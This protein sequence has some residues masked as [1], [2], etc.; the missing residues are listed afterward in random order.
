M[1]LRLLT[2]PEEFA[3][4]RG[5]WDT[6]RRSAR[7]RSVFATHDWFDAA[8]A[9]QGD[10]TAPYILCCERDGALAGVLPLALRRA[11]GRGIG[12][13]VLE[14]LAVPDTQ[15]CDALIADE[16]P[17][18]AAALAGELHRR[19]GQWDALR[20][21]YLAA[22][23]TTATL[24][25]PALAAC[26]IRCHDAEGA[27]N[28][29]IAL[30]GD[31]SA[32]YATRS[33]RLKKQLNLAANRLGKLGAVGI[34]WLNA[35]PFDLDDALARI[36]GI[37][38]R[39]WK[40]TTGNSLDNRGPQ[41]FLRAIAKHRVDEG[42][43]SIWILSLDGRAVAMEFQLIDDGNIYAL[44]SDFDESLGHASPGSH[45]S[46]QM[47]ERLFGR[48][49]SRYYMGPGH[50]AYKHRWTDTLEPARALTAYA[51]TGRG[52]LLAAWETSVKPAARRVVARFRRAPAEA[53]DDGADD[54][55]K[56]R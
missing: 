52:R 32:F 37:S 49:L 27:A 48:G 46:R 18:V 16:S 17:D 23:S 24:F 10:D 13:R 5:D 2:R 36:T 54:T 34:E 26:G 51:P 56:A 4:L 3:A 42:G 1:H 14:F 7:E 53:A 21:R 29:W 8:L 31:W 19:R 28:P 22:D 35:S 47:L 20:L 11:A 39:S 41:A 50:N 40:A 33:R 38:A 6:L 25:A 30:D 15:R 43:V 45:L 44:R 12:Q 55:E 9:W